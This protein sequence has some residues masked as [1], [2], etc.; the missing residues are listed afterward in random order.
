MT[1]NTLQFGLT[2]CCHTFSADV[3]PARPK[4]RPVGRALDVFR[5]ACVLRITRRFG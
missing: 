3:P 1:M 5:N 2:S 4:F